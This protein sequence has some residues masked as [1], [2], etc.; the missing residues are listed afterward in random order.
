MLQEDIS[1]VLLRY[2][3]VSVA[4]K[5]A[6]HPQGWVFESCLCSVRGGVCMFPPCSDGFSTYSTDLQLGYLP[7]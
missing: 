2:R 3:A 6:S 4:R 1:V 7:A 5:T